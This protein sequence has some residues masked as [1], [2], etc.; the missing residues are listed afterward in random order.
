MLRSW[1]I[2]KITASPDAARPDAGYPDPNF[3]MRCSELLR[4]E[5]QN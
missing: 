4:I 5:D 3:R 2:A 1:R